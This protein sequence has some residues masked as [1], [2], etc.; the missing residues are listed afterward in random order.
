MNLGKFLGDRAAKYRDKTLF[1]FQDQELSYEKY[2][3]RTNKLAWSLASEGLQQGD[4]SCV[5]FPNCFEILECYFAIGKI[6]AI[7]IPLNPMYTPREIKYVV[8]NSEAKFLITS[9]NDLDKVLARREEMPTLE[10]IF[11]SGINNHETALPYEKLIEEASGEIEGYHIDPDSVAMILYTSGTTGV[12][13]GVM[14]THRGLLENADIMVQTLG[15]NENDRSLC[16]LPMFHLFATAFDL[17]QM[18]TAGGST[19]LME[20]FD[21]VKACQLI[22]KY[23][24]T[25]IIGVPTIFIY[26]INYPNR[27]RYDLSSLR[28]GDTGGGPVPVELKTQFEKEVGMVLV[29]SYGLTE[30]SPVVCVERPGKERR[31]GSCGITLSGMET[32]VVDQNGEDVPPGEIGELIL[33]GPNVMVGYWKMSEETAKTVRDGW[34]HTGDLMK[35]DQ[36]GY[37]YMVD[38]LKDMILCGGYNVYPKEIESVLYSHPSILEVAVV[39]VPDDVKGEIPKAFVV[40]K[41]EKSLTKEEINQFCRDNL[42]AYKVPREIHLV[43]ELPK[44]ITGKI[45]KVDIREDIHR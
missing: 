40:L 22:E 11:V 16:V 45:R 13:K 28:I 26:L 43:S 39:G 29:E 8:N 37:I 9:K 18:M 30:A 15:F 24:A 38:R 44:T 42:A 32:R 10:K 19:I 23:R 27:K 4:R 7:S 5:L 3:E 34:L 41:E 1:I 20:R 2:D 12:P 25:V 36:D 14:L 35:K 31:L 21:P 6:G 17:L 33:K